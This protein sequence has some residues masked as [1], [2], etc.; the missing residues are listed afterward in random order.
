MKVRVWVGKSTIAG[1]GVFTAQDIKKDTRILRYVGE[2]IAKH[3]SAKR[4]DEGN[5]YI[6]TL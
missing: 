6:F 5:V 4:I 2:R 1:Q 3:E